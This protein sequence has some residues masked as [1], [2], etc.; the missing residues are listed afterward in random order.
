MLTKTHKC[1][2]QR[3]QAEASWKQ[4]LQAEVIQHREEAKMMKPNVWR[5]PYEPQP[6][7]RFMKNDHE[8]G[9]STLVPWLK[10]KVERPLPAEL[11]KKATRKELEEKIASLET[12]IKW[13]RWPHRDKE[14]C[15][16]SDSSAD[17]AKELEEKK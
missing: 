7:F 16:E 8:A 13:D 3:L 1:R 6:Y 14:A 17:T 10:S 4:R 5:W 2:Q 15:M 11:E 12:I 9:G